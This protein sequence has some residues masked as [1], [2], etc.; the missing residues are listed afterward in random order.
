MRAALSACALLALI[1]S[2]AFAAAAAQALCTRVVLHTTSSGKHWRTERTPCI[3]ISARSVDFDAGDSPANPDGWTRNIQENRVGATYLSGAEAAG[4][5]RNVVRPGKPSS[6]GY[7]HFAAVFTERIA[8]YHRASLSRNSSVSENLDAV[9]NAVNRNVNEL[10]SAYA[11]RADGQPLVAAELRQRLATAN[12]TLIDQANIARSTSD[13]W[14]HRVSIAAQDAH[15]LSLGDLSGRTTTSAEARNRIAEQVAPNGL[16]GNTSVLNALPASPT[17]EDASLRAALKAELRQFD[18][19]AAD[20]ITNRETFAEG[21]KA[22]EHALRFSTISPSLSRALQAEAVNAREVAT[23]RISKREVAIWN[24][25]ARA[26]EMQAP[27]DARPRALAFATFFH[28]LATRIGEVLS[29]AGQPQQRP[30]HSVARITEDLVAQARASLSTDPVASLGGLFRARSLTENATLYGG[31]MKSLVS[32]SRGAA[33]RVKALLTPSRLRPVEIASQFNTAVRQTVTAVELGEYGALGIT[34]A[35]DILGNEKLTELQSKLQAATAAAREEPKALA[36]LDQL[37]PPRELYLD[38]KARRAAVADT[39]AEIAEL[40]ELRSLYLDRMELL[41]EYEVRTE[42][43]AAWANALSAGLSSDEVAAGA[44]ALTGT[45]ATS[46]EI[47]AM[48]EQ[49]REIAVEARQANRAIRD[50][51]ESYGRDVAKADRLINAWLMVLPRPVWGYLI[52][53]ATLDTIP[54]DPPAP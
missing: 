38:E 45:T 22:I 14:T 17:G 35:S 44:Y 6:T 52:H 19:T 11:E 47:L 43:L 41:D 3:R 21:R 46:A 49:L 7:P 37:A 42:R 32:W 10:R 2:E 36:A 27:S 25:E 50:A 24:E 53:G 31:L 48:A 33:A 29:T 28:G 54:T 13:D 34:S 1:P 51:R 16:I 39:R 15:P 23:G 5:W 9:R 20:S 26:W 4:N 18:E 12:H 8:D 30:L 40:R